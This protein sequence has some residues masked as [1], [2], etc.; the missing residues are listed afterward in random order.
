MGVVQAGAI[1]A[2]ATLSR[3]FPRALLVA[4]LAYMTL[5]P[6]YYWGE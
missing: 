6:R 3:V 5:A 1:V 2:P 4:A